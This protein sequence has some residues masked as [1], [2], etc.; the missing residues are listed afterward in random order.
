MTETFKERNNYRTCQNCKTCGHGKCLGDL[1]DGVQCQHADVD[2][3][4]SEPVLGIATVCD[5][6]IPKS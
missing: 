4:S 5:Q 2:I 1:V 3:H 6:W